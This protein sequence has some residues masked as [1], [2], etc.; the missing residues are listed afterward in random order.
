MRI[1]TGIRFPNGM[2][3]RHDDSGDPYQ[4]IVAETPTKLLWSYDI[5]GPGLVCNK[6]EWGK[7]PGEPQFNALFMQ[8]SKIARL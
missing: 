4:L 1:D 5:K 6:R 8:F 7:M 2:A 3:V